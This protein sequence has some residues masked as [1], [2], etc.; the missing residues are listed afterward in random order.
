MEGLFST[1]YVSP[2]ASGP[3]GR[4]WQS[5]RCRFRL[6]VHE[7]PPR[8]ERSGTAARTPACAAAGGTSSSV[9]ALGWATGV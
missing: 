5:L 9:V 8:S 7:V 6:A 4:R 1:H 3:T 2:R